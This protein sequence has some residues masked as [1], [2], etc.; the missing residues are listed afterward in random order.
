MRQL[1]FI[2][3]LVALTAS[4]ADM[5]DSRQL[6]P[7]R[8]T[9]SLMWRNFDAGTSELKLERESDQQ[10]VYSSRSNASGVFRAF[11]SNEISQ[12]SWLKVTKDGIRPDRY[13]GDDGSSKTARDISLDF[14]WESGRATGV[15]E[16]KPVDVALEPYTQDDMSIQIALMYALLKEQ[17]PSSFHLIDKNRI[18]EY[19]YTS[20]GAEH[21]KTALGDI[22]TVVYRSQRTGSSRVTRMWY[23]PSLGYI[24][25]RGEQLRD[26][27]REW[28]MEIKSLQ[29]D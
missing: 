13:R 5:P 26:G 23:A 4:A 6:Q 16:D 21:L 28:R 15:A 14:N 12:T 17:Q 10:Y 11:F 25:V 29:R 8:A 9:Y 18:K 22:D 20:E 19:I 1:T 2:A 3:C 7:F 24:P 27:K